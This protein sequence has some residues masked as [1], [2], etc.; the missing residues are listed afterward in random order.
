VLFSGIL[1]ENTLNSCPN[2]GR[3]Q[4]ED[5]AFCPSCGASLKTQ[6]VQGSPREKN[7]PKCGSIMRAGF[8]VEKDSPLSLFT[9]GSGIYW[10]PGEAGVM[11]ERVGIKA[12]A[13]P[14]CGYIEHYIRNLDRDRN[15]IL[16][17]ST[18]FE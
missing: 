13:C 8:V 9:S 11:G 2:C 17:A 3:K 1:G 12:Y 18:T 16:S 15:T 7:C 14:E 6:R 10:T 4:E 5:S